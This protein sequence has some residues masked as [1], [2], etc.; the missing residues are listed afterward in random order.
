MLDP[1]LPT[2]VV[3]RPPGKM[4]SDTPGHWRRSRAGATV[5]IRLLQD[6]NPV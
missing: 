4:R 2:W 1:L 6:P 3:L 5:L